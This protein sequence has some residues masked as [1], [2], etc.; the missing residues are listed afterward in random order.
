M[1]EDEFSFEKE[2]ASFKI[3]TDVKCL[4]L[5]EIQSDRCRLTVETLEGKLI[6]IEWSIAE[7]MEIVSYSWCEGNEVEPKHRNYEDLNQ[8]L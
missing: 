4:E 7:A 2:L 5:S 1:S 3:G 6:K 8:L